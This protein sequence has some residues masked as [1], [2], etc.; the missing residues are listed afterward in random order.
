MPRRNRRTPHIIRAMAQFISFD[1]GLSFENADQIAY[2]GVEEGDGEKVTFFHM[3]D[4][5][6]RRTLR[7][8]SE[9]ADM[10]KAVNIW[11]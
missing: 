6:T 8:I 3:K 10:L 5:S 9:I 2:F 11:Y 7:P 1:D 4:G